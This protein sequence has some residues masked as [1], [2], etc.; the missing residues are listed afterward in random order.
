MTTEWW[1][2]LNPELSMQWVDIEVTLLNVWDIL[3]T[4][5]GE[6]EIYSLESKKDK[7]DTQLYNLLLDGNHTYYAN[8][9]LVHNKD[10]SHGNHCMDDIPAN[11]V[12]QPIG[13]DDDSK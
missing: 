9:Y 4:D 1:K 3:I 13:D 7:S 12:E 6:V 5:N 10:N 8:G 2:S 11:L